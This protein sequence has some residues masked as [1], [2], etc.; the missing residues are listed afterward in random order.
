MLVLEW[1]VALSDCPEKPPEEPA[2]STCVCPLAFMLLT[3]RTSVDEG[4]GG[5]IHGDTGR[6]PEASRGHTYVCTMSARNPFYT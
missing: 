5:C 1:R 6:D 2:G 3:P 4:A